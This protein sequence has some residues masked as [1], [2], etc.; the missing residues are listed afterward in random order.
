MRN[1]YTDDKY[2]QNVIERNQYVANQDVVIVDSLRPIITPD[3][4]TK[5]FMTPSDKCI[6]LYRESLKEW[7]S[8]GWKIDSELVE[9]TRNRV[10]YAVPSPARRE[11]KGWV[12]DAI[13]VRTASKA[14]PK[15]KA[16][17]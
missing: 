9:R 2:D 1:C 15:L 14:A 13:P 5:E 16:T 17:G 8:Y 10:A 3:T 12:Q 4:N 11:Q 6:L 7:E